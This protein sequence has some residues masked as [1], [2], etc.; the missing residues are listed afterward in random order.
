MSKILKEI[1]KEK[2]YTDKEMAELIG[3]SRTFYNQ[4][5]NGRRELGLKK[6]KNLIKIFPDYPNLRDIF[7]S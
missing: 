4:V 2:R 7:L 3:V 6:Q 1:Q 5:K